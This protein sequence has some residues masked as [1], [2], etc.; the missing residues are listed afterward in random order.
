MEASKW[1][2]IKQIHGMRT[3]EL[4]VKNVQWKEKKLC[5]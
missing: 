3:T 5:I 4:D 2:G 1:V